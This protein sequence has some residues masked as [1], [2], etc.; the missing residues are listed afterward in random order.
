LR[1]VDPSGNIRNI[2]IKFYL[3]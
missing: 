2:K 3:V 1:I